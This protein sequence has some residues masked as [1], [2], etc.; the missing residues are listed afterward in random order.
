MTRRHGRHG[1]R[2]A[3]TATP[4]VPASACD[5]FANEP[6]EVIEDRWLTAVRDAT[7][8]GPRALPAEPPR[9]TKD[10]HLEHPAWSKAHIFALIA[11]LVTAVGVVVGVA[12][13]EAWAAVSQHL[14]NLL[15]E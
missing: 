9:L 1:R 11:I 2:L 4:D 14:Q 15:N 8:A 13:H 6:G 10:P 12:I 5:H 3:L 7:Q